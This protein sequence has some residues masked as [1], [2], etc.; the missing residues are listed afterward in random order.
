M[1]TAAEAVA[2]TD[3][4]TEARFEDFFRATYPR[5]AQASLLL[6]GD[7]AAAEDLAQEAMARALERWDRVRT[8]VSPEGYVYRTALNL[9]RKRLRREAVLSR[10]RVPERRHVPDPAEEVGPREDALRLLATLSRE[11]REAVVLTEWLGFTAEE[12]GRVLGI[13]AASVRGR[14]HRARAAIRA[15]RGEG[16][17]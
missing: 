6:T 13:D 17:E 8:M 3:A 2:E 9:H 14:V 7:R 15:R 1:V 11:Q 16:D 12:A 4:D 10:L 5:L